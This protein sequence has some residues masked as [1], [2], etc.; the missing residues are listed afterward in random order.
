MKVTFPRFFSHFVHG[1]W[2]S[3]RAEIEFSRFKILRV[4]PKHCHLWGSTEELRLLRKWHFGMP[5]E[6]VRL[7]GTLSIR[8]S[9]W[10]RG[11]YISLPLT[12]LAYFAHSPSTCSVGPEWGDEL[13]MGW[14]GI[15]TGL[16]DRHA[17]QT[18]HSNFYLSHPDCSQGI[19]TD[20]E[21]CQA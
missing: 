18:R 15:L 3:G 13:H 16:P 8:P 17:E 14:I 20:L 7:A 4:N 5:Q 19:W 12:S 9:R 21:K 6:E 10:G 1:M 2:G 11:G